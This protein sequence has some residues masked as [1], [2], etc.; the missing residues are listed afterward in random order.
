MVR[1]V[2]PPLHPTI[3][4]AGPTLSATG[5]NS[6]KF[7]LPF[8]AQA[9]GV[10]LIW[11]LRPQPIQPLDQAM[12]ARQVPGPALGR[13]DG[14]PVHSRHEDRRHDL[15]VGPVRPSSLVEVR[16]LVDV[17]GLL[18]G[19]PFAGHLLGFGYLGGGHLF[20]H[21]FAVVGGHLEPFAS[22]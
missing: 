9:A 3:C 22:C 5:G 21:Y 19:L 6:R 2:P 11:R 7:N 17:R 16:V 8:S 10:P 20:G 15:A 14:F 12:H 18:R 1:H 4:S 13:R